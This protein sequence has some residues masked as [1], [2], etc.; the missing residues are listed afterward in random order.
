MKNLKIILLNNIKG[1]GQIGDIKEVRDG[2]GRNFLMPK[3]LAVLAT[4]ENLTRTD[5]LK[6]KRTELE[7]KEL[8]D[9][10]FI[11][12]NLNGYVLTI[13]A[14]TEEGGTFYAGIDSRKIS[15]ELKKSGINIMPDFLPLSEPIKEVGEYELT[16]E[17]NPEI[18]QKFTLKAEAEKTN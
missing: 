18:M 7:I 14:L 9:A 1:L 17:Y 8:N 4:K 2:Y 11:A 12:E 3:N 10:K 13:K 6:Q 5:E 15:E 16:F